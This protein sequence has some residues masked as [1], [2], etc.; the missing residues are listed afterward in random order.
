[1]RLIQYENGKSFSYFHFLL[2]IC[3]DMA[4]PKIF[5]EKGNER[6]LLLFAIFFSLNKYYFIILNEKLEIGIEK[7]IVLNKFSD[8]F[9]EFLIVGFSINSIKLLAFMLDEVF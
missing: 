4:A 9:Y 3:N 2:L 7:Q 1:M 6:I 8:V 5:E